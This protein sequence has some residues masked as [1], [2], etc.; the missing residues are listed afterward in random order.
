VPIIRYSYAV[1]RMDVG[2]RVTTTG[3]VVRSGVLLTCPVSSVHSRYRVPGR[4][5]RL[6]YGDLSHP[7]ATVLRGSSRRRKL[8]HFGG[9]VLAYYSSWLVVDEVSQSGPGLYT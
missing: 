9:D 8:E 6:E 4:C 2:A 7:G 3:A 5:R 1:L